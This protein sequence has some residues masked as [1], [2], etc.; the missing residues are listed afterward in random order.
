VDW[1]VEA[2]VS[3]KRAVPEKLAVP[4]SPHG[5]LPQ[6]NNIKIVTAVKTNCIQVAL[7]LKKVSEL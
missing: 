3:E 6:K 5:A 4:T 7:E 2:N 1:F